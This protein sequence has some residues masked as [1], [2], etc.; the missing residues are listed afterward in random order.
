MHSQP[1][2]PDFDLSRFQDESRR[3]GVSVPSIEWP[4]ELGSTNDELAARL[5]SSPGEVAEYAV[6]G[7]D[8]QSGGHGRLG[9]PWTVPPR[10]SL[11]FSVPVRVPPGFPVDR[12]GWLPIT[13]GWCVAET[14]REHEIAAGV[15]WPNDVLVDGKKICGILTRACPTPGGL[16]VIIGIGVNVAFTAD[17]LP[18]PTATSLSLLGA[19]VRREELL[20]S[21]LSRLQPAIAEVLAAGDLVHT[22]A[23]ARRVRETMV[24][25]GSSV[26]VE[27]PGGQE[28]VGRARDLDP[29][30]NLVVE[31]ADGEH[32][33]TAG[34]VIHARSA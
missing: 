34:D 18:V 5:E 24:T 14:L 21:L 2:R 29:A 33:I 28:L 17:E 4:P 9:R 12:L 1:A 20:A 25:L 27:L 3:R 22:T 19:E 7:T 30:G 13:A 15:K 11:T 6:I 23:T 26:R 31:T 16:V 8:F 10:A 32:R